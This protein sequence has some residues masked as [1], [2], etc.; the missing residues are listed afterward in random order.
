MFLTIVM[1]VYCVRYCC[2]IPSPYS[3]C[4]NFANTSA[5]VKGEGQVYPYRVLFIY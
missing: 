2:E 5:D 1:H 4:I 3:L